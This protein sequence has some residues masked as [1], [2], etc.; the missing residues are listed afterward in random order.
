TRDRHLG[1][2]EEAVKFRNTL[3][4]AVALGGLAA[5]IYFYEYRGEEG[6]E[7]AEA[8]EK[9]VIVF[10]TDKVA[11]LDLVRPGSTVSLRKEAGSWKMTSPITA[12]ADGDEVSGLL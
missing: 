5:W 10:E 2:E 12:R 8:A 6:R 11:G 9:K 1:E 7:K 4:A 3:L